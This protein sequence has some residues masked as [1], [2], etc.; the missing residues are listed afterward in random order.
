MR[1]LFDAFWWESGPPSGRLVVRET[2]RAWSEAFPDD[3]LHLATAQTDAPAVSAA[4]PYA[5]VHTLRAP[6]HSLAAVTGLPSIARRI[7]ADITIA[8]NFTPL[9]TRSAVFLH[10]VLYRTNPEWFSRSERAYLAPILPLASRAAHILT[11][12]HSEAER[13]R[14]VGRLLPEVTPVGLAVAR[15]LLEVAPLRPAAEIPAT[16]FILCVGR[17]NVRKNLQTALEAA[18]SCGM[19]TAERPIVI[20]GE[21]DGRQSQNQGALQCLEQKHAARFLGH[22]SDAELRWLYEHAS[23]LAFLSLDEG[24]GLPPLEAQQFGCP[25]IASDISVFRETLGTSATL[26]SPHDVDGVAQAFDDALRVARGAAGAAPSRY[27]WDEVSRRMR[28][29]VI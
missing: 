24:F 11:S 9:A 29:A 17:L 6:L 3:E 26:L 5:R 25:V 18:A 4:A 15:S 1:V 20:V 7:G 10:D 23:A 13:I 12:S 16:G 2:I 21:A 28:A 8:Q 14:G 19:V 27:Q 22:V